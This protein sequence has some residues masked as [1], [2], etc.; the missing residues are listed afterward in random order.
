MIDKIYLLKFKK[1]KF[2]NKIFRVLFKTLLVSA[3]VPIV[4]GK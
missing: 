1:L 3:K 2:H 4:T